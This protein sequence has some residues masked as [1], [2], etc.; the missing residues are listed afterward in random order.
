MF[1]RAKVGTKSKRAEVG[2]Q[3]QE[4]KVRGQSGSLKESSLLSLHFFSSLWFFFSFLL[5]KKKKMPG[6]SV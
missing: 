3:K 4:P 6:E 2:R 5:L 1:G